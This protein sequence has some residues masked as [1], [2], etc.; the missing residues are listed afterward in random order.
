MTIIG[1]V[2]VGFTSSLVTYLLFNS[3]VER[4]YHKYDDRLKELAVSVYRENQKTEAA[5]QVFK[6]MGDTVKQNRDDLDELIPEFRNLKQWSYHYVQ[7]LPANKR[8]E[9]ERA[10]K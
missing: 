8:K 4:D 7:Y 6:Y 1:Y 3:K 2:L 9:N 10:Y 5:L